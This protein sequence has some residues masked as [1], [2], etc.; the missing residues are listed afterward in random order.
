MPDLQKGDSTDFSEDVF[1][2]LPADNLKYALQERLTQLKSAIS[3]IE[4]RL[5]QGSHKVEGRLR[6]D[7]NGPYARYFRVRSSDDFK[8]EYIPKKKRSIAQ[9]L[10]Q[11][12]YDENVLAILQEQLSQVEQFLDFYNPAQV[13]DYYERLHPNRCSMIRPVRLSNE[14]FARRWLAI[15]YDPKP[16]AATDLEYY[17][18]NGLRVRSKS[19]VIIA[20]TLTHMGV[21]FKYECPC[22]IRG[23]GK[24]HPDFTCLNLRSRKTILWEHLGMMDSP[25]YSS[26]A[27]KRINSYNAAGYN[28]GANLVAT[29]ETAEKPLS[30]KT[31]VQ[32][33]ERFLM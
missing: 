30:A 4:A 21:P 31:V 27:A 32:T 13:D 33:I 22:K 29:F 25:D 10:A 3:F 5:A 8:G 23:L 19:E 18:S 26:R 16:F 14:E 20:D 2:V 15:P 12:D 1:D 24:I 28:F 17:T 11:K 6:I 7:M 9:A